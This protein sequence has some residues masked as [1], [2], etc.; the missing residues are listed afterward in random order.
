MAVGALQTGMPAVPP[1]VGNGRALARS[2]S[3]MRDGGV[4]GLAESISAAAPLTSGA[5]KLVPT[6]KLNASL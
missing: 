3:R 4:S 1:V 5:E 2:R 6:L